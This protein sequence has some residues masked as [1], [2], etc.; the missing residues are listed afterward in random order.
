MSAIN[1]RLAKLE[2]QMGED[3]KQWEIVVINEGDPVP[4]CEGRNL[5]VVTAVS[6][7]KRRDDLKF[8]SAD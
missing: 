8:S 5:I 2:Q 4:D 6:A 1:R 7:Q 3:E